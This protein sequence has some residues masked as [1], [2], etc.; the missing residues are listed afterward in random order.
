MSNS[1]KIIIAVDGYS[2]CGKS[3][4]A[5]AIAK[6]FDYIYI[7]TGAMYRAATLFALNNKLIGEGFFEKDNL[8]ARLKDI[9]VTFAKNPVNNR[10]ET[11]L[12]NVNVEEEI[13]SLYV[14]Q[15]V[16]QV[17]QVKEV[18]EK[19]VDLQRKMGESKGVVMDGRDIGSVVFPNAEIKLFMTAD[20]NVRAQRRFDE[21]KAKGQEVSF[22]DIL[23]NVND[24][25]VQDT[26]RAESPLVKAAD[27]VVLDNSYMTP[28]Q[29]MEWFEKL[30]ES[31]CM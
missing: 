4:F 16:S 31:K 15:F 23:K 10:V 26:T 18:R 13:R 22:D 7:D 6:K 5:K 27:A 9:A 24:R 25:D 17:S 21:L 20:P 19:M 14:S 30:F 1:K 2:S 3:T 12:N 28:E 11:F 29:Q 8:I